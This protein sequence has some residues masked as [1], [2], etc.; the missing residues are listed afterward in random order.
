MI[1]RNL[2]KQVFSDDPEIMALLSSQDIEDTLTTKIPLVK[3]GLTPVKGVD[4]FTPEEKKELRDEILSLATPVKGVD[5]F[6]GTD[7]VDGS[8]YVLTEKDKKSIA[9][10][11]EVPVVDK[12]IVEKEI[13]K[14]VTSKALEK[15]MTAFEGELAK[16]IDK[17]TFDKS[18]NDVKGK[19][20]MRWHGG[21]LSKVI[22]DATLTGSGTSANPLKVVGGGVNYETPTGLINDSNVTFTVLN[23]PKAVIL[24]GST[25]FQNDGYT[26]SGLT[27]T[28]LIVPVTG[29][30]LRS[31][32]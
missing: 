17:K 23:T 3:D 24:N 32:Y 1:K 4:Y 5:Y 11:I 8:D 27:I 13:I 28:M 21:G 7:G 2:L 6:D 29:S 14:E 10:S 18:F 26:L 19:L 31:Q 20:D 16:F 25:Y 12:V 15:K 30:T 9:Q 22:T